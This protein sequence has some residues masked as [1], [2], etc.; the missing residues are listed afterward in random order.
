MFEFY[1]SFNFS[2]VALNYSCVNI[3]VKDNA[4]IVK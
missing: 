4:I 2:C 1:L 3:R